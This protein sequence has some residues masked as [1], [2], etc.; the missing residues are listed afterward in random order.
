MRYL[1]RHGWR[2]GMSLALLL[3]VLTHTLGLPPIP[4]LDRMDAL[5]YKARLPA[6][7][8]QTLDDRIVTIA[9]GEK[10]LAALGRW[11]GARHKIAA[12]AQDGLDQDAGF[13]APLRQLASAL[14]F[15][16]LCANSL[17]NQPVLLG[18]Y[19]PMT[20]VCAVMAACRCQ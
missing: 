9:V 10:S 11:P 1:K 17:A 16:G 8:P 12:L 14:D 19:F 7:M 2:I 4:A 15:D 6:T 3:P 20:S 13:V 18:D 5:L